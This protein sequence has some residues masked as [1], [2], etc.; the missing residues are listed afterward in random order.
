[1]TIHKH[2]RQKVCEATSEAR[3]CNTT[4]ATNAKQE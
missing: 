3:S 1:M 2:R 4:Y